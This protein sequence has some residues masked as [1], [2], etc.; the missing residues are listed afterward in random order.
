MIA[1]SCI[2]RG[3]HAAGER[4]IAL[5][6]R[7][8][9]AVLS[10]GGDSEDAPLLEQV[11]S[12][13]QAGLDSGIP[14]AFREA[15]SVA[16]SLHGQLSEDGS[17]TWSGSA[18]V[19]QFEGASATVAHVGACRAWLFRQGD[20]RLLTQDHTI[21]YELLRQGKI[22]AAMVSKYA[23]IRTRGLGAMRDVAPEF[24]S[25]RIESGDSFALVSD[26][27]RDVVTPA[28][29]EYSLGRLPPAAAA[30]HLASLVSGLRFPR[31]AAVLV[32]ND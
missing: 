25:I 20:A 1:G 28:E 6:E 16:I 24:K 19:L 17:W 30:E 10:L 23:N 29:V 31:A 13:F 14:E 12:A 9:Y 4:V 22:E 15:N 32:L 11:A 26:H 8:R 2:G 3:N 18:V 5:P 27:L 7:R 21:G